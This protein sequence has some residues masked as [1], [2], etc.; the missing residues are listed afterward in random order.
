LVVASSATPQPEKS[1]VRP[2]FFRQYVPPP[3]LNFQYAEINQEGEHAMSR[4]YI[5]QGRPVRRTGETLYFLL[6]DGAV[7][8]WKEHFSVTGHSPVQRPKW[9]DS[10]TPERIAEA[11]AAQFTDES[12]HIAAT[13]RLEFVSV[14][15]PESRQVKISTDRPK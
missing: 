11:I 9:A 5:A 3:P 1:E 4:G 15:W 14:D 13:Q 10:L 7:V 6:H 8:N 2:G 12:R